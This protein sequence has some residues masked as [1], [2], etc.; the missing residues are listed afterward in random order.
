MT[1]P[2]RQSDL[3]R[4]AQI[5]YELASEWEDSQ[6]W[7]Y[8]IDTT[9]FCEY[10][11][12][13]SFGYIYVFGLSD[14]WIKVGLTRRWD[15]R[16]SAVRHQVLVR[17][18]LCVEQVWKTAPIAS[19]ELRRVE[20]LVKGYAR[21]IADSACLFYLRDKKGKPR[22]SQETEMFHGAGGGLPGLEVAVDDQPQLTLVERPWRKRDDLALF[23]F[24]MASDI[25][26]ADYAEF[27]LVG[28]RVR[29]LE[30]LVHRVVGIDRV[31][32]CVTPLL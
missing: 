30:T 13:H 2:T 20:H 1:A 32:C 26:P 18:G 16:P 14:G 19:S 10:P 21:R 6:D 27:Q 5:E 12:D 15:D 9:S 28:E 4:F 25:V 7:T 23:E 3:D 11:E 31:E 29:I 22:Q 8:D 24:E 17:H